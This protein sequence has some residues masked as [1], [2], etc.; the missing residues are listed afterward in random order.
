M[1]SW[2]DSILDVVKQPFNFANNIVDRGSG[3]LS[4]GV[5]V[6]GNIGGTIAQ[7][8]AVLSAN[9]GNTLSNVT[10]SLGQTVTGVAGAVQAVT[11]NIGQTVSN[12]G[13]NVQ[14]VA[15]SAAGTVSSLGNNVEHLGDKAVDGISGILSS[16]IMLIGVGV[17]AFLLISNMNNKEKR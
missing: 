9:L 15:G 5:S 11:G 3:L 17:V 13:N 7:T 8:P 4:Q 2:L 6:V 12:L 1:G 16:P 14:G 10:N